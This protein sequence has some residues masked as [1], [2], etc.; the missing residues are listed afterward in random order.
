MDFGARAGADVGDL[1]LAA[2]VTAATVRDWST[3]EPRLEVGLIR[4]CGTENQSENESRHRHDCEESL[5][6][7]ATVVD[8][9]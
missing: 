4:R 6:K 7:H 3:C 8:T 1:E 5:A 9:V 2:R